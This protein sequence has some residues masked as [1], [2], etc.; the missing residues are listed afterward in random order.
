ML[1][2]SCDLTGFFLD[3]NWTGTRLV[4]SS[5]LIS[6]IW[7]LILTNVFRNGSIV[8]CSTACSSAAEMNEMSE[9]GTVP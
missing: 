4:P 2:G 6:T 8:A 7:F 5:F 9:H 3:T 1:T